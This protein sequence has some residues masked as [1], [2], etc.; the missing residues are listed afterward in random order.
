MCGILG[1]INHHSPVDRGRFSRMLDTLTSRGPDDRGM[2]FFNEGRVALGHRRLSI[3]D[4]SA[5]GHQPMPNEDGSIWLTF[6]GEIYN[7]KSLRKQLETKGHVFRSKTDSETILHAYE[8]WG[9][10]CVKRLRGIFAIGIYNL[11]D[12]SL[13]LARD[14]VGVK[15]LYYFHHKDTFAFASQ[16]KAFW[17][18]EQFQPEVNRSAFSYYLGYG[19]IPDSMSIFKGVQKLLPG[20]SLTLVNGK[21]STSSYWQL[22]YKPTVFNRAEA[23]GLIEEKISNAVE[24]QMVSDV[25]IGTLLSGGVDSTIIT[26]LL[27]TEFKKHITAFTIGFSERENDES[28]YAKAVASTLNIDH[29]VDELSLGDAWDQIPKILDTFDEPFHLTGPFPYIALSNLI[30]KNNVKVVLGGDGAD[31]L[32]AGYRWYEKFLREITILKNRGRKANL[33]SSIKDFL[34]IEKQTSYPELYFKY[35]GYF[36]HSEQNEIVGENIENQLS[37]GELYNP[38]A[39][40]FRNDLPQVVAAQIM[41]FNCFLPDH[42]LT[43]VDRSSMAFGLEVRVPFLDIDL[44]NSIF[45]IDHKII[46]EGGQRKALFKKAMNHHLPGNI[47]FNRKQGFNSPH[48]YWIDNKKRKAESRFIENGALCREGYFDRK[49]LSQKLPSMTDYQKLCLVSAELWYRHWLKND[50]QAYL[51]VH[52]N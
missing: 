40:H 10:D 30:H 35:N 1:Q 41:D 8:E 25:P 16:P 6:N 23:I 31:E 42:C 44:V 13:F 9:V 17:D 37:P 43:K 4:L 22:D 51:E 39:K 34:R 49:R 2:E 27:S 7:Y 32:F 14:H 12:Q 36:N 45:S 18:I 3:I 24:A 38:L 28:P 21:V 48:K 46:F 29:H 33:I 47:D 52:G 5:D 20:H 50:K 11:K 15:P 19:N 26:S